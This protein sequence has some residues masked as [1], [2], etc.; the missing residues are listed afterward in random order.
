MRCQ[1]ASFGW[2]WIATLSLVYLLFGPERPLTLRPRRFNVRKYIPQIIL[3]IAV[4][5]L[6]WAC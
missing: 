6:Q 4:A 1:S 3:A 2:Y 5:D